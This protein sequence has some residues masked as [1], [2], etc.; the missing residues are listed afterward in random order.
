M[1]DLGENVT[2]ESVADYFRHIGIIKT[3]KKMG[4]TLINLHTDGNR[5]AKGRGT[6]II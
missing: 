5:E 2:I 6:G 3:N 1:Q 4:Q